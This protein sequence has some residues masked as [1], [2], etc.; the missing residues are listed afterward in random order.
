MHFL[1]YLSDDEIEKVKDVL[2]KIRFE[3]F[4]AKLHDYD[5]FPSKKQPRVVVFNIDSNERIE[6]LQKMIE[7]ELMKYKFFEA[8]K[9]KFKTHLTFGR[10]D[11]INQDQISLIEKEKIDG[12]WKVNEIDL[13]QSVLRGK[14]GSRY[15]ILEKYKLWKK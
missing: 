9:R 10:I 8:E 5:F 13:M 6:K 2:S 15:K 3:S 4:K 12:F 7:I 14:L 11:K 1:G